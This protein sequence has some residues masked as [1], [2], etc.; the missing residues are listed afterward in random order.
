MKIEHVHEGIRYTLSN[1]DLKDG[2]EVF[3]IGYGRCTDD[4]WILHDLNYSKYSSGFPNDPHVIK[5]VK[6]NPTYKPY[7][8]HTDH[9]YSPIESYYKIIKKEKQFEIP[10]ILFVRHEWKEI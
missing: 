3:P 8:V 9:G 10:S 2:D 5:N 4:G 6:H 7:E 1:D